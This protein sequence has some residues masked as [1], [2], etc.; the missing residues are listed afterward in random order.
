MAEQKPASLRDLIKYEPEKYMTD[1]E[2]SLIRST[3]RDNPRLIAVL[4]K[5]FLPT[6]QDP[7]LPVEEIANDIW[8]AG[9]QWDAVPN[10]QIKSLVVAR[11]EAIKFIMGGFISLKQLANTSEESEMEA[12]LRRS[13]DSTK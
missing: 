4:R 6:V 8:F 7:A 2:V 10:E 1:D 12:A 13:K 3:F 5:V 11:Q 9:K